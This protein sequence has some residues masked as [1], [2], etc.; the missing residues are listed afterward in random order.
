[1]LVKRLAASLALSLA[2][3]CAR[4]GEPFSA[5]VFHVADGDTITVLTAE[6]Q[7]VRVRLANIDAP[8]KGQAF[9]QVC[10]QALAAQVYQRN[11]TLRPIPRKAYDKYGRLVATVELDGDDVNLAQLASGCA[12][13]YTEF[14]R[15]NQ[16][17]PEFARYAAAEQQARAGR[18]GLWADAHPIKPSLFRKAEQ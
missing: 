11:V 7:Q 13:H 6:K 14:A 18:I 15:R 9:G 3:L 2:A 10:R 5:W 17:A 4:A 16:A 12:W 1:M 8:E